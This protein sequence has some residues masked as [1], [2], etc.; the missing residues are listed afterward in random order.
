M[1]STPQIYVEAT[2]NVVLVMTLAIIT[3]FIA[4]GVTGDWALSI[5]AGVTMLAVSGALLII[6]L[7]R[8]IRMPTLQRDH[9]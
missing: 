9:S 1:L 8:M 7:R 5:G 2:V 4:A 3:S 6:R